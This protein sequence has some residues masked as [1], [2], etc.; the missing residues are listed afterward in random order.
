MV[1]RF[2][3]MGIIQNERKHLYIYGLQQGITSLFY[4]IVTILFG[5]FLKIT[6]HSILFLL[7]FIPIRIY[8]GGF[9][10]KSAKNCF[11]LSCTMIIFISLIL[12]YISLQAY[13][14]VA[15]IVIAGIIIFV[16]APVSDV[17]KPFTEKER[18]YF[19]KKTRLFLL[20]E[21]FLGV[22]A[23]ATT[24]PVLYTCIAMSLTAL[25]VLLI[26]G[27]LKNR[28]LEKSSRETDFS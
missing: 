20:S 28:R 4:I 9:H 21:L 12:K 16:L 15:I 19:K 10:A 14:T 6:W 23:F 3:T 7:F 13:P 5:V 2:V 17:N 26:L 18:R 24:L 11:F 27:I 1:N 8:G 22:V 25:S